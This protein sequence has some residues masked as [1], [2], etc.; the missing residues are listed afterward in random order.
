LGAGGHGYF[1]LKIE[2]KSGSGV[3]QHGCAQCAMK[4]RA[5]AAGLPF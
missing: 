2:N 4:S 5:M 3:L 1:S